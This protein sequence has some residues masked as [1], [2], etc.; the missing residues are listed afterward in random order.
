MWTSMKYAQTATNGTTGRIRPRTAKNTKAAKGT[1]GSC[2][3]TSMPSSFSGGYEN[4]LRL[5]CQSYISQ[6]PQP[7]QKS[8]IFC[9]E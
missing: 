7:T 2:R 3:A 4:Q 1:M 8:A 9:S 5:V 6:Y